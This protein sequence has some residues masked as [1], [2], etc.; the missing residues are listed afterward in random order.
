MGEIGVDGVVVYGLVGLGL[1]D[2]SEG[3]EGWILVSAGAGAW[4]VRR[5]CSSGTLTS[6][7]NRFTSFSGAPDGTS[8]G[9]PILPTSPSTRFGCSCTW[10]AGVAAVACCEA[11]GTVDAEFLNERAKGEGECG[12]AGFS[13]CAM[14]GVESVE[15][16]VEVAGVVGVV[17]GSSLPGDT[18]VDGDVA[19]EVGVG[20]A[21]SALLSWLGD[22]SVDLVC[23]LRGGGGGGGGRR[24]EGVVGEDGVAVTGGGGIGLSSMECRL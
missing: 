12:R 17:V 5:A 22:E 10:N 15:E 21:V 6:S 9:D 13:F 7:G 23:F 16:I 2:L 18:A 14:V 3:R 8:L 20:V 24:A 11:I 1:L 19:V 4:F